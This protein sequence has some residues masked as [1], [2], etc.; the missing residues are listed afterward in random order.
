MCDTYRDVAVAA[1]STRAAAG[2]GAQVALLLVTMQ[3]DLLA[4]AAAKRDEAIVKVPSTAAEP[5][6]CVCESSPRQLFTAAGSAL[7]GTGSALTVPPAILPA[8]SGALVLSP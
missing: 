6:D 2:G 4:R 8:A 7:T 1:I 5:R 3:H